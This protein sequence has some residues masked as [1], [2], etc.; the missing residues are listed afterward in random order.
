MSKGVSFKPP[1]MGRNG[2][3]A[4]VRINGKRLYL[5]PYGSPEAA[6]KYARIIAELAANAV[7]MARPAGEE[8][9]NTLSVAFLDYAKKECGQSDYGNYRTA[10][11]LLLEIYSGQPIKSFTPKCLRVLQHRFTQQ[12]KPNGEPYSRQFCNRLAKFVRTV[13]N[14]AVGMELCLP[15]TA[16]AL[17]YVPPL[18]E[19]RY[20]VPETEQRDEVPEAVVAKTLPFLLP[21]HRAMVEIQYLSGARPSEITRLIPGDIDRTNDVWIIRPG[22]FKTKWKGKKRF[23]CLGERSQELLKLYL[24]GKAPDEFVFTP[25]TA[26]AE[27]ATRDAAARKTPMTPSHRKRHEERM[28]NPKRQLKN[29]YTTRSYGRMLNRVLERANKILPPDERIPA[30]TLYQ[31]RHASVSDLV[32]NESADVARAVSGHSNAEITT[33]VYNHRDMKIA[34]KAVRNRERRILIN[35]S[36]PSGDED[37]DG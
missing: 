32:E 6:Q 25:A 15:E 24:E 9:L 26:L 34:M 5:G 16:D 36:E 11:R 35:R 27:K 17:K 14:W 31:L 7:P 4:F 29:R 30:W 37:K 20:G 2:D 21:I 28:K 23:I 12:K 18:K 22:Q 19:G 1:K 10:L 8:T 13:F 3:T 33:R